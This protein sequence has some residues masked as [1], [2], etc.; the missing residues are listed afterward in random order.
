MDL[1]S[2]TAWLDEPIRLWHLLAVGIVLGA[3]LQGIRKQLSAVGESV[4]ELIDKFES[5][6]DE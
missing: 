3:T 1:S 6:A 5:D 2:V 4:W